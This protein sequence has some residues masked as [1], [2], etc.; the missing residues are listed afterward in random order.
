MSFSHHPGD[1]PT[2]DETHLAY[3]AEYDLRPIDIALLGN[4]SNWTPVLWEA[5]GHPNDSDTSGMRRQ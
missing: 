5:Y 2:D 1:I 4:W 3:L